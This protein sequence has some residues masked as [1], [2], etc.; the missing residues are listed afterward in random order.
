VTATV[1]D[2]RP[3]YAVVAVLN[4]INRVV[5]RTP[6]GRAIKRFALLEF[7]GRR[8]GRRIRV[9]VLWHPVGDGGYAF[10]PATWRS[11]FE[12][13]APATVT[14]LG[15]TR[16][17]HGTLVRDPELVAGAFNELLRT[18]TKP[19]VTGLHIPSGHVVTAD[20]VVRVNRALIRFDPA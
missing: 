6:I 9:S 17:L 4:P 14:H 12:G 7:G 5:L 1:T 19:S 2:A 3:P 10:S 11:N 8:T 16:P 15:R 20:D 13:G 18:G